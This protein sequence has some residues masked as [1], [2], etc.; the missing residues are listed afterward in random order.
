MEAQPMWGYMGKVL[1][2]DLTEGTVSEEALDPR[3]AEAYVGGTGLGAHYLYNEVPPGVEWDDPENRIIMASGALG[4]TVLS[5]TGSFCL[6]TKGPMTNQSVAT[7]ANGYWGAFLKMNG[8]DAVIVQGRSPG[9][10]Y[11]HVKDGRA[12]LR[13]ATPLMGRDTWEMED[14]AREDLGETKML[15]VFGV[16]PAGE[17]LVRF[18]VVAG[19]RGHVCSKGGCGAVM[20]AK[21]LK[22]IAVVRGA[23][24]VPVFD[25]ELLKEKA[26]ALDHEA[27]TANGGMRHNWGTGGLFAGYEKVG[28]LPVENLRTSKFPAAERLTGQWLRENYEHRNKTCWACSL[29]HTRYMKVP[30]GPYE[31]YEGEEPEYECM[32]AWGSLINNTEPGAMV[33]L[34]NL[35]DRLGIDANEAGWLVAWAMEC[36]EKGIL[37]K[38][39]LDGFELDWGNVEAVA[40]LLEKT[41]TR[42]G[43][44]DLLAEGVM[45]A[46]QR[47]G[48]EAPDLGVYT[49]KGSTPRGH[50]HRV[51]WSEMLDTCV[52]STSTIQAGT[53]LTSPDRFGHPPVSDPFSPW[54]VAGANAAVEGWFVFL[55]SLGIC[56]FITEHPE[57]TMACVNAVT[58]W[59]LTLDDA[60]TIGRRAINTLRVFCFRHGLDPATEAP[61]PRYGSAPSDGPAE[62]RTVEPYF[63]W[64]KRHYFQL[65]GWDPET[66]TPLPHTL[67]S[68]GLGELVADLGG[69][70]T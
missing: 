53:R 27:K 10:V 39:D 19:D 48:G 49:L 37:T 41:S 68:L 17:N 65:M 45:R 55:D 69:V 54:E 21:R 47:V 70:S 30:D 46:S 1:R 35:A 25:R 7:Q 2:V 13:D 51:A 14:A 15:S 20:G 16:G 33:M 31:G 12:E 56:R 24:Q 4:G 60:L 57:L 67:E 22:A 38:E 36:Y 63:D 34:T 61:S 8:Y 3:V 42:D 64:M 18:A 58:G 26:K 59:N 32:A 6:V 11:L 44:G 9:W 66:G 43:V 29:R 50:D 62:G 23:M 28:L 40:T 52:S 5:G